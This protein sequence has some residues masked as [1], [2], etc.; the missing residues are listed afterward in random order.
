MRI[1]ALKL[2]IKLVTPSYMFFRRPPPH[3]STPL[4]PSTTC[5]STP[6]RD[7]FWTHYR[8]IVTNRAR[9]RK[10]CGP[11]GSEA[12]LNCIISLEFSLN[13]PAGLLFLFACHNNGRGE[14]ITK[15]LQNNKNP[16]QTY[17]YYIDHPMHNF[18]H[19]PSSEVENRYC[20]A[21][22]LKW[23]N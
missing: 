22:T 7:G 4:P 15:F 11:I 16:L 18:S 3:H 12:L 6:P 23:C 14:A 9:V 20:K 13:T 5:S 8:K 19:L 2:L 21:A 10:T 1:S 17:L